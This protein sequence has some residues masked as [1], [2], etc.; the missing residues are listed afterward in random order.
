MPWF[1]NVDYLRVTTAMAYRVAPWPIGGPIAA[2]VAWEQLAIHPVLSRDA[3]R[4]ALASFLF[5]RTLSNSVGDAQT[6]DGLYKVVGHATT[7][8]MDHKAESLTFDNWAID[9]GKERFIVWPWPVVDSSPPGGKNYVATLKG[10]KSG[11]NLHHHLKMAFGLERV[12]APSTALLVLSHLWGDLDADRQIL[13]VLAVSA[14]FAMF[15]GAQNAKGPTLDRSV[16]S[17][18]IPLLAAA[19]NSA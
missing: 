14:M 5:A 1:S 11:G 19:S 17:C 12:L 13:F 6:H 7:A 18:V 3:A 4:I 8:L 9:V 2:H 10:D 15:G 16:A